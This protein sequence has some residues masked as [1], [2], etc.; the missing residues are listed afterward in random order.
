LPGR[1]YSSDSYR[2]LFQGQEH[3][4][5]IN[6]AVGTSYAFEYRIHDPRIG[7]FLSIDPLAAKYPHNSPYAFSENRVM[8]MVELEG[9]EA[10]PTPDKVPE[11]GSDGQG[12]IHSGTGDHAGAAFKRNPGLPARLG[13]TLTPPQEQSYK[14][15]PSPS[16]QPVQ[17]RQWGQ[18]PDA[19]GPHVMY[20]QVLWTVNTSAQVTGSKNAPKLRVSTYVDPIVVS[21]GSRVRATSTATLY[22]ASGDVVGRKALQAPSGSYFAPKGYIG[23]AEFDIAPPDSDGLLPS[24]RVSVTTRV[25]VEAHGSWFQPTLPGTIGIAPNPSSDSFIVAPKIQ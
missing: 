22:N 19:D 1:N 6:G 5:E 7:R 25:S 9:L 13:Q 2:Y 23:A 10:A 4:D 18:V 8:D 15:S 21:D 3:D 14:V 17:N 24:Y 20:K 12:G 16:E 11:A